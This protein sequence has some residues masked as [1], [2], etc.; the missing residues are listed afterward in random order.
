MH[1]EPAHIDYEKIA[2]YLSGELSGEPKAELEQWIKQSAENKN[3]IDEC[4]KIFSLSYQ[5]SSSSSPSFD[6]T[7]AWQ[8]VQDRIQETPTFTFD[9]DHEPPI[10]LFK[11]PWVRIA[12]IIVLA[13]STV[14]YFIDSQQNGTVTM[15]ADERVR[16]IMLPDSS[17]VIL[18]PHASIKYASEFGT[19]H[20]SLE[21]NGTAYFD[22]NRNENLLFS[23]K[24]GNGIVEVLG[25]AF[26]IEELGKALAVTVERGRVKLLS[27]KNEEVHVILNPNEKGLLT[28]SAT[29]NQSAVTSL[30][31]LYWA[32]KKLTYRREQLSSVFSDLEMIFDKQIQFIPADIE[33]CRITAVFKDE[34]FENIMAN[35]ALSLDFEYTINGK[36]VTVTSDG[37]KEN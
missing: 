37:C 34:P 17:M 27:S 26:V 12:A 8:K 32:N 35:L 4:R 9:P 36:V 13:L 6:R 16:E 10:P 20:R 29:I 28:S 31:N 7:S 22:V 2:Q 19:H 25:T 21:L 24:A 3:V 15:A 1:K 23:I 5:E 18:K 14:L 30:N 11:R 33:N